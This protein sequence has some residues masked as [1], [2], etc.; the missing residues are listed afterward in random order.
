MLAYNRIDIVE[1]LDRA[2]NVTMMDFGRTNGVVRRWIRELR[3]CWS[4]KV[5][6]RI[7]LG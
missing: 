5:C 4:V 1:N 7:K 3:K 2:A 6:E